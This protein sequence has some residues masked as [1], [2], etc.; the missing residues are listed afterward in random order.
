MISS[1]TP[2]RDVALKFPTNQKAPPSKCQ[3][4]WNGLRVHKEPLCDHNAEPTEGS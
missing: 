4:D 1:N 2:S 3:S